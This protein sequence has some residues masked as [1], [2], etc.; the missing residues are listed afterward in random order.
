VVQQP[1]PEPDPRIREL[2]P[3]AIAQVQLRPDPLDTALMLQRVLDLR[4]EDCSNPDTGCAWTGDLHGIWC[5]HRETCFA[6]L[7]E[8]VRRETVHYLT[9]LGFDLGQ[10]ALHLQRSWPVVS[11]PGQVVGRHHHPNAHLSAVYYLNGDGSGRSGCLRLFDA[12]G[13]NEL[14]PGLAVGHGGPIASGHPRNTPWV[15]LAP[16][17]GLLVLFPSSTDHAVLPSEEDDDLRVSISFDLAL[18]APAPSADAAADEA[19]VTAG[20]PSPEYLA[21][22]PGQWLELP[23]TPEPHSGKMGPSPEPG[24]PTEAQA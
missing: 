23:L 8:S 19:A 13:G 6:W 12:R 22:H 10:V 18:T 11:E 17:A 14:V 24:R 7:L 9:A 4:G 21:P 20:F 5:L 16:R 15:D 3:L 2:F 1:W